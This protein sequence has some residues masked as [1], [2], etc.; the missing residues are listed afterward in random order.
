MKTKY[1]KPLKELF[2]AHISGINFPNIGWMEFMKICNVLNLVDRSLTQTKIDKLFLFVNVND[3]DEDEKDNP[4]S[5]LVRYEFIE[6][7][8]RMGIARYKDTN[9]RSTKLA[10]VSNLK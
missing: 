8:V 2:V 4:V 9:Q 6:L 7:L 10:A 1:F 3:R 5:L